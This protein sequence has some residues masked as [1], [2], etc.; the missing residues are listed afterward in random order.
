MFLESIPPVSE[1]DTVSSQNKET[2]S[3]YQEEKVQPCH[4][5]SSI[6]YG[7]QDVYSQPQNTQSNSYTSVS[8]QLLLTPVKNGIDYLNTPR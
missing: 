7:G 1:G 8:A 4:L 2:S 6:Y 3:F 5:S